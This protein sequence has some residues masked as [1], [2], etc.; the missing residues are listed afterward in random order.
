M[1]IKD[2]DASIEEVIEDERD[3][4]DEEEVETVFDEGIYYTKSSGGQRKEQLP[5]NL[6]NKEVELVVPAVVNVQEQQK[7][8]NIII[9]EKETQ[10]DSRNKTF[11]PEPE[12]KVENPVDHLEISKPSES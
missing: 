11:G 5:T 7:S 1:I 12:P 10:P 2:V 8:T 4:S 3:D 9:L 6:K